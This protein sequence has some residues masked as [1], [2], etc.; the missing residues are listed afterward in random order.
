[1]QFGNTTNIELPFMINF[2]L[3]LYKKQI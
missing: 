3:N 2:S 1:M